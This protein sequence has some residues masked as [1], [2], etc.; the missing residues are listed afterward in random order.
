MR[1]PS[2]LICTSLAWVSAKASRGVSV[3]AGAV[4]WG[5]GGA[6]A[7]ASN[8]ASGRT[9]RMGFPFGHAKIMRSA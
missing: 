9:R 3:R 4:A 5:T 7:V 8:R 2:G 6:A 1:L